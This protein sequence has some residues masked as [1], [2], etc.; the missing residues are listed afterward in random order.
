MY[1]VYK[2]EWGKEIFK[3][4]LNFLTSQVSPQFS[5]IRGTVRGQRRARRRISPPSLIGNKPPCTCHGRTNSKSPRFNGLKKKSKF[6]SLQ[7]VGERTPPV[8]VMQDVT[9]SDNEDEGENQKENS[10]DKNHRRETSFSYRKNRNRCESVLQKSVNELMM[11]PGVIKTPELADLPPEMC[12]SPV[13]VKRLF[14]VLSPTISLNSHNNQRY[15]K[16]KQGRLKQQLVENLA[17]R[18]SISSPDRKA[19]SEVLVADTP[20][21]E[22]GLNTR[23]R[24]LRR[25]NI[26]YH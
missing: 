2:K 11:N 26:H 10:P 20:E 1:L 3:W 7:F 21:A 23:V 25:R 15:K 17:E 6:S 16:K 22:Y 19:P 8:T 14:N 4:W 13:P 9:F 18:S 24:R 12:V 5:H